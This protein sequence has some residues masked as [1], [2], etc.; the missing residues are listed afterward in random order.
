MRQPH[1]FSPLP[2]LLVGTAFFG[3]ALLVAEEP[4]TFSY[5]RDPKAVVL[6]VGSTVRQIDQTTSVM[7]F[8][9][10]RVEVD[11]REWGQH[12]RSEYM[13]TRTELEELLN[14][15][16]SYGLA[17]FD[18]T[19]VLMEQKRSTGQISTSIEDGEA[20]NV[21]LALTRFE[22]GDWVEK[23]L[24]RTFSVDA[25]EVA[26]ELYPAIREYEGVRKLAVFVREAYARVHGQGR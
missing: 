18:E 5:S 4:A 11:R 26:V 1:R 3:N 7:V 17:E 22:R 8:G 15:V 21:T 10:G 16:V 13:M 25:P 6:F 12:E 24:R 19:R 2:F 14:L 9:D 20:I 23:N